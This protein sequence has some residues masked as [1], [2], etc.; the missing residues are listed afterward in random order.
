MA[1]Q[2]PLALQQKLNVSGFQ[3]NL[4]DTRVTTEMDVG[5]KKVRSRFTRGVDTYSASILLD[6]DDVSV[7]ESFYKTTLNNGTLPFEFTDP[8]TETTAEF[9]FTPNSG[10]SISPLGGRVFQLDMNWEL[11]P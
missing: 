5:P 6:F 7:F 9:R 8:F 3:K 11:L 4:G 1:S 10:V 2:W